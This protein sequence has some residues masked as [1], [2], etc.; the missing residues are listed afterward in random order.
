MAL[1]RELI[2]EVAGWADDWLLHR[3]RTLRIPGLQFAIAHDGEIVR[4][5]AHGKADL[6][7]G[8]ELR[9]D[10]L[11]RVASHSKTFTS[12]AIFQLAEG[13]D[14]PIRLDDKV[15]SHLGW[16][17]DSE[18][19]RG[20]AE[21][22]IGDLLGHG[23]GVTRDGIDGDHWQLRHR[24]PD[25]AA[26]R[27]LLAETPSPYAGNERFHYS[28]IAYSL[29][30]L[31]IE[32][33]T[34]RSYTEHLRTA[35][36]D[37]LGLADTDPDYRADLADRYAAGHTNVANGRPRLPIEHV[38]TNA[39][40]AATGFTSTARD[41]VT[42]FSAHCLGDER[43]LTDQSKRR[44]QRPQWSQ[45][46]GEHYGLGVHML[47]LRPEGRRLV[48]HA[49]GYPGHIT[50][51]W[52]DPKDAVVVS[53][54]SNAIDAPSSDLAT[55]IFR[56][57]DHA[58]RPDESIP[59]HADDADP[60]AFTGRFESL[61]AAVDIVALDGRLFYVPLTVSNPVDVLGELTIEGPATAR[62]TRARD[63]YTSEGELFVFERDGD[64][65]LERVR[66]TSGMTYRTAPGYEAEFLS[67]A[68]VRPVG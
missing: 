61:W 64:G 4:S 23:G 54:L 39:M 53:V 5:G 21:L 11:F 30:G 9:E 13:P 44:M 12:T 8:E 22:T 15:G 67:G 56:M 42:Y 1:S 57:I 24:F 50:Q 31:A 29:L 26:L 49:G 68:R 34:G 2:D 45:R 16:L 17:G 38:P 3:Q 20:V 28:N 52:F 62:L 48:G 36:I 19:G 41:L 25:E 46:G 27:H 37:P 10:H 18:V 7:T 43:L 65:R 51:T 58:A 59:P 60:R 14:T 32:E 66:C 40:A 47:D 63:G 55:G 35:V 33:V 6:S